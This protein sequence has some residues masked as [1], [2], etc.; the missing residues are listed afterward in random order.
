MIQQTTTHAYQNLDYYSST[1][2]IDVITLAI[3]IKYQ[4][5]KLEEPNI[6]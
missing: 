1:I 3:K 6:K 4:Q 5:N 2:A